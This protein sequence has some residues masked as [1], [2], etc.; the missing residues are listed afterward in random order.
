MAY[1]KIEN[2]VVVQKQPSA[3]D[4][5][6]EFTDTIVCGQI[7]DEETHTVSNPIPTAQQ[8][9]DATVVQLKQIRERDLLAIEYDFGDGRIVQ[10]RPD[11]LAIFQL[12]IALGVSKDWILK[13]DTVAVLTTADMQTAVDSGI[14]QGVVI[15]QTYADQLKL[16]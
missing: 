7:Y 13:D 2:G 3:Q 9:K 15:W 1:I 4:G 10:S 14:T 5:F 16:L 12:A 8:V 6:I 11:D